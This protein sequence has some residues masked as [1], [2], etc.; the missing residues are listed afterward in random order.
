MLVNAR[1]LTTDNEFR[2]RAIK[3]A[4]LLTDEYEFITFVPNNIVG[5]PENGVVG[6]TY[7]F[8]VMGDLTV[9]DVTRPVTFEI[10]VTPTQEGR[11]EG[12]AK[13]TVLYTDF[14]LSIPDSPF[15]DTVEDEVR[16]EI[17]FVTMAVNENATKTVYDQIAEMN[18]PINSDLRSNWSNLPANI[19]D[20]ERNGIRTGDLT[21]EQLIALFG[22]LEAALS[23]EGYTKVT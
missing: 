7:T 8:Q 20:F 10:T 16:L 17:D 5:L 4:I 14:E 2:N 11:L 13:T 6:D 15:V 3:N 18:F 1:V 23:V 19:L 22:F 12:T 9:T 21:D